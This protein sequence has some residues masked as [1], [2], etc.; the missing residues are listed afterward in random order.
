MKHA[1]KWSRPVRSGQGPQA[2]TRAAAIPNS[3]AEKLP[4]RECGA[5]SRSGRAAQ[6]QPSSPAAA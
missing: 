2:P 4:A 3:P 1:A 6:A 5:V